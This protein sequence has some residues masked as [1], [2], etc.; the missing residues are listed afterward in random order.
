MKLYYTFD[1]LTKAAMPDPC[2]VFPNNLC[3]WPTK[4]HSRVPRH[5]RPTRHVYDAISAL[6]AGLLTKIKIDKGE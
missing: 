4:C 6:T 1:I 3:S 5:S 2:T